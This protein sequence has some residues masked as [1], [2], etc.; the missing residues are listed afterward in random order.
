MGYVLEARVED[1][2]WLPIGPE[3]ILGA[4][5]EID[6]LEGGVEHR[7]RVMAVTENGNAAPSLATD[8]L[9]PWVSQLYPNTYQEYNN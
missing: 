3:L 6:G 8:P 2:K 5:T 1:G 7:F 4:R 9:I